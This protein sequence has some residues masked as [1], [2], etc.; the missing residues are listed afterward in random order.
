MFRTCFAHWAGRP[1]LGKPA[2][3]HGAVL[4]VLNG[5]LREPAA[6]GPACAAV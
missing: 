4:Y 5:R 6:Q 1:S 2:C 3:V